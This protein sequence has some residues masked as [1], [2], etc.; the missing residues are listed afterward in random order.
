MLRECVR[1]A[2]EEQRVIVIFCRAD[3][4]L[5]DPRPARTKRTGCGPS[6]YDRRVTGRRS[7]FGDIGQC[8]AT[9]RNSAIVTYGNGCLPVPPGGAKSCRTEHGAAKS[10]DRRSALACAAQRGGDAG[11]DRALQAHVLIVDECRVTGSQSEALMT[12][13]VEKAQCASALLRRIA[14]EDSPSSP[15][16]RAATAT[17]PR[18]E[19]ILEAALGLLA[20]QV[21]ADWHRWRCLRGTRS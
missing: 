5:H 3:R 18:K 17:L 4:A 20:I 9:A 11:S 15:L 13:V 2:R 19:T 12:L 7:V 1:L 21:P 10:R 16:G 6:V 14:A 8:T